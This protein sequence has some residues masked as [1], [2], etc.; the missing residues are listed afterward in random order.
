MK[1]VV[2]TVIFLLSILNVTAIA[3]A[4]GDGLRGDPEAIAEAK[5]MVQ[6]MGGEKIWSQVASVRFV[7]DWHPYNRPDIYREIEILDMTGVRSW[8]EMKSEIYHYVRAYSPEH[9][10]W[11]MT[12]G[13][14]SKGSDES[15]QNAISRGPFSL[16]RMARGVAR[17]DSYYEITFSDGDIPGSKQL[18]FS[19]PDGEPG[20]YVILNARKEPLVWATNQYRYT[21]GPMKQFGSVRLPNWAVYDNGG[22]LYEMVSFTASHEPPEL[23]L[24]AEPEH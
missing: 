13:E 19:G 24:F 8:V 7:H 10:Y 22:T 2:L 14:F 6:A 11:S 21:F 3:S 9:G 23:S 15:L 16:Y 1:S 17:N 12:N 4:Q 20:G 5:A 18:Q